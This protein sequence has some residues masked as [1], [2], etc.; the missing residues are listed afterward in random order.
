MD[1]I[2]TGYPPRPYQITALSLLI[3]QQISNLS[4][5]I[6]L[7]FSPALPSPSF[8]LSTISSQLGIKV[9]HKQTPLKLRRSTFHSP[10]TATATPRPPSLSLS[11]SHFYCL[12]E[13][14]SPSLPPP[15]FDW[16]IGFERL[17]SRVAA[18]PCLDLC[19]RL[20]AEYC[21][22]F[23]WWVVSAGLGRMN[24]RVGVLLWEWV[25]PRMP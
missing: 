7:P 9:V 8:S 15:S 20:Y 18:D 12:V 21:W 14:F 3:K 16:L 22:R 13:F 23:P 17:Q 24:E 10:V 11:F 19:G 1:Q 25:R 4:L 6:F 2:L 5:I